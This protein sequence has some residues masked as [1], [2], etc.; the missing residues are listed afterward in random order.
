[1][2]QPSTNTTVL[3]ARQR[4]IAA[5]AGVSISTVSR[6]FNK[7]PNIS[8]ATT[9]RVLS[10]AAEL[11][12]PTELLRS[13]T[14]LEHVTLLS[15]FPQSPNGP[16]LEAFHADILGGVEAE[17]R[18]QGTHFSYTAIEDDARSSSI[19]LD[20][21]KRNQIDGLL[22]LAIDN[23]A[24]VEQV[25][26][27]D[28][29]VVIINAD[30]PGLPVDT[31]LPDN[32]GGPWLAVNHLVACGH[33]RI[34]HVTH[35]ER[36][37]LRRRHKAYRAALEAAGV[38]YDPALVLDT[39]AYQ[40][41]AYS[42]MHEWLARDHPPFTAVFC[43]NDSLAAGVIR[44]LHETGRHVPDDVSVVGFDDMPIAALLAPPLTTIRIN[45]EELGVLAVRRLVDRAALPTLTPMRFE[46]GTHLIERQS[47]AR[48]QQQ[49]AVL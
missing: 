16:A 8:A 34:L 21:V 47:V 30:H 2:A 40:D 14:R 11:G 49:D 20:K 1:M 42:A 29:P 33:R 22:L 27:A 10:A 46:L 17:C 25:L 3:R 23:R 12:Y 32:E 36:R 4:E 45:R 35:L 41:E 31:L 19:V 13:H 44:A 37:T 18:R 28:L 24:L 38:A 6:V 15:R 5:H 26:A 9:Q 39:Q 43:A 7:A 48:V